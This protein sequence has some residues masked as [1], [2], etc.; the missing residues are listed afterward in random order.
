MND[1][2]CTSCS[3]HWSKRLKHEYNGYPWNVNVQFYGSEEHNSCI[4]FLPFPLSI[5]YLSHPCNH[6]EYI[7]ARGYTRWL[8]Y[9]VALATTYTFEQAKVKREDV[10]L[11]SE[12]GAA[13]LRLWNSVKYAQQLEIKQD[14]FETIIFLTHH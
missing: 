1:D 4:I 8:Q 14:L 3:Y 11:N 7:P 2:L 5:N 9:V 12:F 6:R 13:S 10:Q